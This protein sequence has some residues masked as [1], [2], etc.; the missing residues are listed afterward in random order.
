M[1]RVDVG[2]RDE[3]NYVDDPVRKAR[4]RKKKKKT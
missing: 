4:S 2:W 3:A 1:G